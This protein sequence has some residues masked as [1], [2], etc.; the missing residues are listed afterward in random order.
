LPCPVGDSSDG[1]RPRS[2][3]A[4]FGLS[5]PA[6]LWGAWLVLRANQLWAPFPDNDPDGARRTMQRFY[7]LVARRHEEAFDAAEAARRCTAT[8]T[9]S[10][11]PASGGPPSSA[12]S[13]C[14]TPMSGCRPAGIPPAAPSRRSG[15]ALVRS[16]A[17]LLAAVHVG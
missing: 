1:L 17:A 4:S 3:R 14:A 6:T 13:R 5:W 9:G 11:K 10:P 12:H 8:S 2:T 7:G 16:Y 15:R